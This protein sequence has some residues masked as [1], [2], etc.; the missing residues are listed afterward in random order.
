MILYQM[1]EIV[2]V[3]NLSTYGD[4][5]IELKMYAYHQRFNKWFRGSL[6]LH[7]VIASQELPNR[8]FLG[9]QQSISRKPM[10]S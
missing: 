5:E 6:I 8:S 4:R 2:V 7:C 10:P 1:P 9:D 3:Q